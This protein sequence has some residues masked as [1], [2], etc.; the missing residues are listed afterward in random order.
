MS[1]VGKSRRLLLRQHAEPWLPRPA[2]NRA[3]RL[4]RSVKIAEPP[5]GGGGFPADKANGSAAGRATGYDRRRLSPAAIA[6]KPAQA[7]IRVGRLVVPASSAVPIEIMFYTHE[8][9]KSRVSF[10]M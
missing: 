7:R 8:T 4:Q 9:A 1:G 10:L 2:C 3:R 5:C 6:D